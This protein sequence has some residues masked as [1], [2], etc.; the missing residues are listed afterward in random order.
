MCFLTLYLYRQN[1]SSGYQ[2]QGQVSINA[3]AEAKKRQNLIS[4]LNRD[5][6]RVLSVVYVA[7]IVINIA[8]NSYIFFILFVIGYLYTLKFALLK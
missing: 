1:L 8:Q 5:S 3:H 4:S 7:A 6:Q 2:L